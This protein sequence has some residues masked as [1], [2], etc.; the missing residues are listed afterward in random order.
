[1]IEILPS[2]DHVVAVR[3][4]GVLQLDDYRRVIAEVEAKLSRHT[5]IAVMVDLTDFSDITLEAL[6]EDFRYSFGKIFEWGRFPREAIVTDKGWIQGLAKLASPL[7]PG[8]EVRAFPSGEQAA[9]MAW[10][11]DIGAEA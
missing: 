10:A 4:A 3:M 9:A 8:I 2:P 6:G 7:L 1:M 5:K 11:A